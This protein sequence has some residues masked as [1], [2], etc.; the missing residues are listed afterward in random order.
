MMYAPWAKRTLVIL[1]ASNA[2]LLPAA[3][4][5]AIDGPVIAST[6]PSQPAVRAISPRA[7]VGGGIKAG[8]C[9][10][11]RAKL[12]AL[13][14]KGNT[15]AACVE[16]AT[17][18]KAPGRDT[19]ALPAAIVP[20]PSW[21]ATDG[22]SYKFTR[23][24]SCGVFSGVLTVYD[25][26]TGAVVGTITFNYIDYSYTSATISTWA[27]QLQIDPTAITGAG[28]GSSVSGTASCSGSCRLSSVKFPSQ[29]VV[30]HRLINGESYYNT[31]ATGVGS[32]GT[33]STSVNFVFT[34]PSWAGPSNPATSTQLPVRCDNALPGQP[35]GCVFSGYIPTVVYS[36]S[37]PYAGFARH[38]GDAQAS[39]L[40]GGY[41]NGVPLTRLTDNTLIA[42]NRTTACPSKYPRPAGK[43]CDEYP[44][45]SSYQGAYTGGGTPRTFPYC[46]IK[47]GSA[48]ST[49]S[50]GYS[51][52]MI[53]SSQ[54]S[55][56]G[57]VLGRFYNANRVIS[58][59]PFRV[60]ITA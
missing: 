38:V 23:T 60:W 19:E 55:G 10:A 9:A 13:A 7:G 35:I 16:P 52:C 18:P 28:A 33:S 30:V 54:N 8:A 32:V 53:D 47:L 4:A 5:G 24:D 26:R 58:R 11:M 45:A 50:S 2:I 29:A 21:C 56:A 27:H 3:A 59:D 25:T 49:G 51:I 20:A 40:P 39:G 34:N 43:T 6:P 14:S 46:S 31:T 57:S 37:G 48:G 17:S 36:R 42:K 41:P 15:R 1:V 22:Q 12:A 44:F